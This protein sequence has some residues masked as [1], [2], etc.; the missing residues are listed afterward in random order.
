MCSR[1]PEEKLR[2]V[3]V[4]C[5]T[6]ICRDCKLTQHEGHDTTDVDLFASRLRE[7]LS[8]EKDKVDRDLKRV[9]ELRNESR[10]SVEEFEKTLEE[11][12]SAMSK[13]L[14]AVI[15]W[16]KTY[17]L[18]A[19]AQ[20][21]ALKVKRNEEIDSAMDYMEE[22]V[23]Y[24]SQLSEAMTFALGSTSDQYVLKFYTD[25]MKNHEG[26]YPTVSELKRSI[27]SHTMRAVTTSTRPDQCQ[28]AVE[29]YLGI[30]LIGAVRKTTSNLSMCSVPRLTCSEEDECVVTAI[31]PAHDGTVSVLYQ[32][33]SSGSTGSRLAVFTEEGHKRSDEAVDND[34]V[35]MVDSGSSSLRLFSPGSESFQHVS[36]AAGMSLANDEPDQVKSKVYYLKRRDP[37]R[38]P[39]ICELDCS[40]PWNVDPATAIPV[41]DTDVDDGVKVAANAKGRVF[42]VITKSNQI[43]SVKPKTAFFVCRKGLWVGGTGEG[44]EGGKRGVGVGG[45]GCRG[46]ALIV[47]NDFLFASS[48]CL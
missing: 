41:A 48:W 7:K 38:Y 33:C 13:K 8:R 17:R 36:T 35:I 11:A 16:A 29:R 2:F 47:P 44:A 1:H 4:Q 32:N 31:L 20:F 27:P 26:K 6:P 46:C 10:A 39:A 19:D 37:N 23:R 15:E 22:N 40:R 12:K 25:Y 14:E 21:R 30:P 18:A 5:D 24:F 42:A 45:G 28:K 34:D 3:C 43:R 9:R